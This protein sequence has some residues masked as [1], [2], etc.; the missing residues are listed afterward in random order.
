MLRLGLV[1][2]ARKVSLPACSFSNLE[3]RIESVERSRLILIYYFLKLSLEFQT[4]HLFGEDA[5]LNRQKAYT[6]KGATVET[7][8]DPFIYF[9]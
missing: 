1:N 7:S 5:S 2:Q 6:Q 3:K 4:L 8:R 9:S